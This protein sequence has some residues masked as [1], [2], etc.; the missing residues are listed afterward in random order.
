MSIAGRALEH[1]T[2]V[3]GA[4]LNSNDVDAIKKF[5]K[6]YV[7]KA[8]LPYIEDQISALSEIVSG[9]KGIPGKKRKPDSSMKSK[10]K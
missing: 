5:L 4:A 10:C 3:H 9:E 1:A 2:E 7:M 6:T 8:L